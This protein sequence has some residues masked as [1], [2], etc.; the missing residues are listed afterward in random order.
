MKQIFDWLK[1]QP[2]C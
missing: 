1:E 2:P